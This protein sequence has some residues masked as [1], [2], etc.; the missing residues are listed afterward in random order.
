MRRIGQLLMLL[1]AG[2]GILVAL[3]MLLGITV[4]GVPWLVAVG[5]GKLTL[6]ASAG[7][8]A[9]GAFVQRLASRRR[10]AERLA[11]PAE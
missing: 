7:L 9:T 8:M 10:E 1:G 4:N 11:P 6:A 3:A 2:V 5:L